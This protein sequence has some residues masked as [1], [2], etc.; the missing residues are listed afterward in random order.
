VSFWFKVAAG[1]DTAPTFTSTLSG[2]GAMT[3]TLYELSMYD[4]TGTTGWLDSYGVYA[5]GGTAY[6]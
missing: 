5:S 4:A 1:S 2:T 6:A 3:A